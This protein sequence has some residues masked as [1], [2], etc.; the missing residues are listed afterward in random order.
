M[1]SIFELLEEVRKRPTMYITKK[2]IHCLRAYLD[3]WMHRNTDEVKDLQQWGEFNDWVEVKYNVRSTQGWAKIIE[4]W[5]LD[6]VEAVDHF[7]ALLTEYKTGK[8]IG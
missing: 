2:S 5:S 4:F 6:D 8:G 3:G 1:D 7:F